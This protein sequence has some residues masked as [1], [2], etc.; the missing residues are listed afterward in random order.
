MMNDAVVYVVDDDDAARDALAFLL[1]ASQFSVRTFGSA[2]AFLD[3]VA[4]LRPGCV[5]T[6]VTMPEISGV[7]LLHR[8]ARHG[9]NW[10]VIVITG[11]ADVGIA[12]EALR[13]G[14]VDFLEKPYAHDALIGAVESALDGEAD[15]NLRK[16][17]RAEIQKKLATLSTAE[18]RVLDG[19]AAGKM[20]KLI[21]LDLGLDQGT[22]EVHR[23]SIM[24]KTQARSLSHLVR[25]MFA[26]AEQ[27]N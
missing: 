3:S 5:I 26:A 22:V 19:L 6:D 12:L 10:P 9:I 7:D 2:V 17:E 14:A 23:A 1:T 4:A 11:Q 15:D 24:T 21:A 8:L 18:Q 20:N 13:A 27:P 16:V 25:M